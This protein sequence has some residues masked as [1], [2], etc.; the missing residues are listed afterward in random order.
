LALDQ[1][2]V[3]TT[4]TYPFRLVDFVDGPDSSVG[5]AYTDMI[6]KWNFGIHQYE[7]ALGT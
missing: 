5:D 6:V 4:N 7:L 1:S 3:A 2:G